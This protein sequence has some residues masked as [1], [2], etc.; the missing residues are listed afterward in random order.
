MNKDEIEEQIAR[1]ILE[2]QSKNIVT[3][4]ALGLLVATPCALKALLESETLTVQPRTRVPHA[5]KDRF[6]ENGEENM[7]LK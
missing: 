6:L 5:C 1:S 7:V 2:S 4:F 3:P